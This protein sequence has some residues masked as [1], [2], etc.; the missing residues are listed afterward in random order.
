[1]LVNIS[2]DDVL[3]HLCSTICAVS[4]FRDTLQF[5]VN[6]PLNMQ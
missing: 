5:L 6:P 3:V 2:N 1:M 4:I